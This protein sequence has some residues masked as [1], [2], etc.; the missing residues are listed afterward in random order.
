MLRTLS[1]RLLS[2]YHGNPFIQRSMSHYPIDETIFGLNEDQIKVRIKIA[3]TFLRCVILWL[4][5]SVQINKNT[6]SIYS[7]VKLFLILHKKN[8]RR[9][10]KTSTRL[11]NSSEFWNGMRCIDNILRVVLIIWLEF[12]E[13]CVDFGGNWAIW[14]HSALQHIQNMV[15]LKHSTWIMPLLWKNFLGDFHRKKIQWLTSAHRFRSSEQTHSKISWVIHAQACVF[16]CEIY[17]STL[18]GYLLW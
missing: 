14:V 3:N 17:S 15:A 9:T 1:G 12:S 16:V 7:C 11:M 10:H 18:W 2:K 13:I 6:I 4:S 8:W 5:N